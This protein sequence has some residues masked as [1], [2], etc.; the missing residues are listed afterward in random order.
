MAASALT[1][2]VCVPGGVSYA[3]AAANADGNYFTNT[4]KEVLLVA[5]GGGSPITV[6]VVTQ[7]TVA[8]GAKIAI[9][10]FKRV[11]YNDASAYVQVTYSAVTSV[12]VKVL[13]L[14][15]ELV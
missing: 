5:N 2:A 14:T 3:E 15:A 1:A 12:T 6:T 11:H 10:P 7:E 9:G 8:N 13:S 4:G